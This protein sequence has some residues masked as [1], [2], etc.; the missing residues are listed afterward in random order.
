MTSDDRIKQEAQGLFNTMVTILRGEQPDNLSLKK[1]VAVCH[2]MSAISQDEAKKVL[3]NVTDDLLQ[4][5]PTSP[6]VGG[7]L[8]LDQWKQILN[9]LRVSVELGD[10]MTQLPAALAQDQQL[11]VVRGVA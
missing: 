7:P 3:Q 5:V 2:A 11:K 9:T 4:Q 1:L 10:M 8:T 6:M